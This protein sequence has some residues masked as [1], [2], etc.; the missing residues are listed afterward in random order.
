MHELQHEEALREF[1]RLLEI[2]DRLRLECPWD[3]KQTNNTLRGL[4]IEETFELS[5]AIIDG[6]ADEIKK[7]LGDIL[8]HIVF[9]AR[10]ASEK[11]QFEMK[12]VIQHII[13]KL[14]FRH[15]HIF[16]D[17]N[18][19]DEKEV[20]RNWEKLKL[21]EGRKSVLEGV[22][23][24]LTGLLK[25][26]RLQEKAAGVGF[27]WERKEDVWE[28]VKEELE[29]WKEAKETKET[30]NEDRSE[31]EFGDLLFTLVNYARFEGINPEDA[32]EKT[33]AKFIRRFRFMEE[34]AKQEGKELS[35][36]D[37]EEM[38][39]YWESSKK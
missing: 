34:T 19:A 13:E 32:L 11:Q 5:E 31:E 21:Q 27:D 37:L 23:K 9:Y 8:L 29:E 30:G 14:I 36:L 4:T 18:V 16:G 6:N 39:R 10:I 15:P 33:N 7:E 12:D 35:D 22:P 20:K 24:S 38:D 2:M 17:V 1:K 3:K 25:S 26:F 28:K